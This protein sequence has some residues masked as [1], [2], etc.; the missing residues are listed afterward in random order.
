MRRLMYTDIKA[1]VSKMLILGESSSFSR[2][3]KTFR[4]ATPVIYI[5]KNS[6]Y[7]N[8]LKDLTMILAKID[9]KMKVE[10]FYLIQLRYGFA[11]LGG[12]KANVKKMVNMRYQISFGI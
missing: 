1:S 12:K 7:M 6:K 3:N 4:E 2:A 5:Q 11:L 10:K 9:H 8:H